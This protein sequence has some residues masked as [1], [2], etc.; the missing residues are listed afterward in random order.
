MYFVHSSKPPNCVYV[1]I[2][3]ALRGDAHGIGVPTGPR[4]GTHRDRG[5]N[6]PTPRYHRYSVNHAGPYLRTC[7]RFLGQL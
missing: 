7:V 1:C 4:G 3:V 2:E 5:S 6:I